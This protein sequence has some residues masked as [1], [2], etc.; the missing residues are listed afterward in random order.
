MPATASLCFQAGDVMPDERVCAERNPRPHPLELLGRTAFFAA[1]VMSATP[2]PATALAMIIF[3]LFGIADGAV[4]KRHKRVSGRSIARLII[5]MAT[6][7]TAATASSTRLVIAA[8]LGCA[9][10]GI[11][12]VAFQLGRLIILVVDV[13]DVVGFVIAK[14]R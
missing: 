3:V 1:A 9:V 11:V 4:V 10:G 13:F 8:A 12:S 2:T 7:A 6:T 5:I 14:I